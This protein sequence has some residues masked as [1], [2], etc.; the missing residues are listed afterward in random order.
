MCLTAYQFNIKFIYLT[1]FNPCEIRSK[2]R[3][4]FWLLWY[5]C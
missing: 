4:K 3:G 1:Y 5:T 2:D